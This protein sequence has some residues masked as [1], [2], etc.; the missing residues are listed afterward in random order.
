MFALSDAY[1]RELRTPPS[2]AQV[3]PELS[4]VVAVHAAPSNT[5][6][7]HSSSRP[8]PSFIAAVHTAT[9][10]LSRSRTPA[11]GSDGQP[12][13]RDSVRPHPNRHDPSHPDWMCRGQTHRR[14]THRRP[15]HRRSSRRSARRRPRRRRSIRRR[16][17]HHR[18]TQRRPIPRVAS[19]HR[20]PR[21]R[22]RRRRSP[23]R[24][25]STQRF[26]VCVEP[27]QWPACPTAFA[28]HGQRRGRGGDVDDLVA[29]PSRATAD[30]CG[31]GH[32]SALGPWSRAL[33]AWAAPRRAAP[34]AACLPPVAGSAR[35]GAA[36]ARPRSGPLRR[37]RPPPSRRWPSG[38][39]CGEGGRRNRRPCSE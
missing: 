38:C 1:R 9:Y 7:E 20:S 29:V 33:P 18:L 14:P 30:A 12:T 23:T 15:T 21:R 19:H 27:P 2:E 22:L 17:R 24:R 35:S 32:D 3:P 39:G 31:G 34:R 16:A 37:R 10:R 28:S 5:P 26:A 11:A 6:F 4:F 25:R 8:G 13:H 36:S